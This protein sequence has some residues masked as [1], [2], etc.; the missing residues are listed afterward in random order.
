ML[1][2]RW[3]H[4]VF[5]FVAPMLVCSVAVAGPLPVRRAVVF[6]N[7][8]AFMTRSGSVAVKDG[9]A[10]LD[11]IPTAAYGT[12]SVAFA[13]GST[14]SELVAEPIETPIDVPVLGVPEL[15][16]ANPGAHVVVTLRA[17]TSI[18]GTLATSTR[19]EPSQQG[20]ITIESGGRF[21]TVSPADVLTASFSSQPKLTIPG[22]ER[23][24]RLRVRTDARE[25]KRDL[26]FSYLTKGIGWTPE[27]TVEIRSD[28]TATIAMRALLV[29]DSIELDDT[30]VLFAV[31]YPSFTFAEVPTPLDV[32]R[33]LAEFF[34]ELRRDRTDWNANALANVM[35][36][37]VVP[38]HAM[39][40]DDG[41]RYD[42]STAAGVEGEAE[43]DLFLYSLSNVSLKKGERAAYP[44]L[45]AS[46]RYKHIFDWEVGDDTAVDP[47]GYRSSSQ[48]ASTSDQVWHSLELENAGKLPWTTGPAIV[49]ERGTPIAQNTLH[50]TATGASTLLRLTVAPDVLAEREEWE[51]SRQGGALQRFGHRY[52]AVTIEGKLDITNRRREAIT[53]SI[54]KSLTGTV[55]SASDGGKTTKLS[56][57]PSA[58]NPASRI[59]W[60][61]P[62]SA[63]EQ[64]SVSYKYVVYVRD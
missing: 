33:S 13:D 1:A 64:T 10:V 54:R 22:H 37:S 56:T 59:D 27:Y 61:I 35:T 32:H 17:G 39:S 55:S 62:L 45:S 14:V 24:E 28:G 63:G 7:G 31:G 19:L 3:G 40:A 46:A 25:G 21:V 23:G 34:Q 38:L 5:A 11:E 15:L 41:S 50:Y 58:V 16:A 43:Q 6:K 2:R 47:W 26:T 29:N 51:A 49:S 20:A 9:V 60:S 48:P 4:F 30:D 36:Q 42:S 52:D 44:I 8:L 53:L 12:L 57:R 18:T